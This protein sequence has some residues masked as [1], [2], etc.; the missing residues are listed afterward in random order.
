MNRLGY[1]RKIRAIGYDAVSAWHD[2]KVLE[3]WDELESKGQVRLKQDP[4]QESYW[5]VYGKPD[6]EKERRAINDLIERWG[7]WYVF[8]EYQCRCCGSWKH[9]DGVGMII[10]PN[11]LSLENPY[12]ID[13]MEG[14][15]EKATGGMD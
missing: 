11:P 10:E 14:T 5:D 6:S 9:G 7:C 13:I 1:F 15:M 3:T 12:L 2:A 4:E 8:C